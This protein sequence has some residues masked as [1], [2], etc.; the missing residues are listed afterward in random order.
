[1]TVEL[2]EGRAESSVSAQRNANKKQIDSC[3]VSQC[4]LK[5]WRHGVLA[6]QARSG[7][8]KQDCCRRSL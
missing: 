7:R 8:S 3:C 6:R 1:M 5:G 4:K 2:A